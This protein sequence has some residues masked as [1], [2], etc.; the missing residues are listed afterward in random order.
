MT[1]DC[2]NCSG[3]IFGADFPGAKRSGVRVQS[4]LSS[5]VQ[6]FEFVDRFARFLVAIAGGV[7]LVCPS[8]N[9]ST[10]KILVS[11]LAAVILFALLMSLAFRTDNKETLVATA[12]YAAVLVVFVGTSSSTTL[13][14]KQESCVIEMKKMGTILI[15]VVDHID[16]VIKQH[17]L[18]I[19][20]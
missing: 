15:R 17:N 12:T 18:V 20:R 1:T 2:E 4:H 6:V 11:V 16:C 7:L 14:A 8:L 5:A 9:P 3:N 19:Y 10:T 13:F